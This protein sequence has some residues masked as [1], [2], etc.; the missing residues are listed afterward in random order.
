LEILGQGDKVKMTIP[1]GVTL[2]IPAL[3]ILDCW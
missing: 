2:L 1:G 3:K